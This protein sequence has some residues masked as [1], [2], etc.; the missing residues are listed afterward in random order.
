VVFGNNVS[1]I[2]D[3][4]FIATALSAVTLP[5]SITYIGFIAFHPYVV[6]HQLT[7]QPAVRV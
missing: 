6:I 3:A 4:A 2:G 1:Y 5:A 7:Y